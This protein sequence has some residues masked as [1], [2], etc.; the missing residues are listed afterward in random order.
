M[1]HKLWTSNNIPR[2][3]SLRFHITSYYEVCNKCL[4]KKCCTMACPFNA[5]PC[6]LRRVCR[7]LSQTALRQNIEHII[8]S[9][10]V[11]FAMEWKN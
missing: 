4:H 10:L 6:F 9:V 7:I 8:I 1:F 5:K 2:T 11:V 3:S